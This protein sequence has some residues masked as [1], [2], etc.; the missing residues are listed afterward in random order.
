MKTTD[1][2][3]SQ[4]LRERPTNIRIY[5]LG[6]GS[7]VGIGQIAIHVPDS[8]TVAERTIPISRIDAE[9]QRVL[10]AAEKSARQIGRL[11]D[12]ARAM[13][14]PV[15]EELDELLDAYQQMLKG[16]RLIKDVMSRIGNQRINA[17]AAVHH[18]MEAI[19]EAFT[20]MDNP[21]LATRAEDIQDI[22]GRLIR[23]LSGSAEQTLSTLKGR[24]VV[25]AERLSPA[26]TAQL[27]PADIAGLVMERGGTESHTAIMARSL[28]LPAVVGAAG[29]MQVARSGDMICFDGASG[30]VI[31]NPDEETL[32]TFRN[33][34][35]AYLENRRLLAC[36]RDLPAITPDGHAVALMAN[37]ELVSELKAVHES[38]AEGVGLFRTEFMFMNRTT[39]PDEEE[40][41]QRLR[42]IVEG[43]NGKP[44]VIRTLDVGGD[45]LS[46][47]LCLETSTNPA[48][49]LRAIRLCLKRPEILE[50]QFAAILRVGLLGPVRILLPMIGCT[51]ELVQI[52]RIFDRC[53]ERFREKNTP[54]PDP[55]P[56]LGIMIE[57]PAAALSADEMAKHCD[58]FSIGTNDLIQYTLA[59]D[60]ADEAVA[61]LY[62]PLHPAVLRLIEF[63]VQAAQRAGIPVSVCGEM[64]GDPCLAG[65]LMGL[66]V[67]TLSMAP[68]RIP[69][70]KNNIRNL[71]I[72]KATD[73][74]RL[75]MGSNDAN[76]IHQLAEG[77]S[78]NE[79]ALPS[80]EVQAGSFM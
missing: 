44:V 50:A 23:A 29:L 36:L 3:A 10:S 70:V 17:E 2:M 5:G 7:G 34:E 46:S 59:I 28:G 42:P 48:L 25:V 41:Y 30:L 9:Q 27:N 26:D 19:S 54:L 75:I 24:P 22:G 37:M 1:A 8:P 13:R 35:V 77:L 79:A 38:G 15:G 69:R 12:R 21:Y 31:I 64:A 55:L 40:Q 47:A 67:H 74:A 61:H 18:E 80:L 60:R 62:N 14:G 51:E 52:R 71:K 39:L 65:V 4:P 76:T 68:N 11:R 43:M 66:G 20:A 57:I 56:P 73:H 33:R 6:V 63:T 16:S 53:V 32:G 72:S 58:F 45:K 49:G 78:M